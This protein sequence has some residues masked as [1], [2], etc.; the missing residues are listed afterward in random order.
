VR[1]AGLPYND[2]HLKILLAACM[3]AFAL[4]DGSVSIRAVDGKL[5]RPLEP[6]GLA[7][8]LFFVA[9]DC[10][11]SNGYAPE[12]QRVCTEYASKGVNCAL[13]Y[14]DVRVTADEVRKHLDEHR[15][16]GIAAAIDADA[17]LAARVGATVT[18]ET[19]VVDH[20]GAVRYRG[21]ID[22]FYVAFGRSRQ[23]V[24]VHDL[25]DALDAL[26]AGRPVA[27]PATE[28]IG[29]YIVPANQRSH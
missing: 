16:H 3:C 24:T 27:T 22:N 19:V 8:V 7:N 14:E 26:G 2:R 29:C 6:S 21:R 5:L 13:V 17:S 1:L 10:P 28:P 15:Y 4:L 18:P 9:T 25:R 12:I 11:V 23:V 20:Q